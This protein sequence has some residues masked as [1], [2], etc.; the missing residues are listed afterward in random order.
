MTEWNIINKIAL[1]EH[2]QRNLEHKNNT[3]HKYHYWIGHKDGYLFC[4][5][6]GKEKRVKKGKPFKELF[7][8]FL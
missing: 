1:D 8:E 3:K 4:G 6:C 5:K 7:D 2:N